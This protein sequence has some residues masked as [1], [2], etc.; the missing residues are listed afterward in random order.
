LVEKDSWVP[1]SV[2]TTPELLLLERG[3]LRVEIVPRPFSLTIRRAGRRLLRAGGVWVADGS[4]HDHFVQFTEGVVAGEELAPQERAL[5]AEVARRDQDA[6]EL[7]LL[8]QGG[9]QARLRISLAAEDRVSLQLDADGAPLRLALEW[10][11]RSE[12]RFVGLGARHRT[13]FDQEDGRCSS[14]PTGATRAATARPRCWRRAGSL[15][16]TALRCPGC[17]PAGA[18]A[19]GF[20]PTPT[21]HA[22]SS[23]A[24]ECRCQ[25]ARRPDR[26][27]WSSYAPRRRR[28]G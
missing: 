28:R 17:S 4:V 18:T 10:D 8:L 13:Q 15:R 21:A 3:V 25:R 14:A 20:G 9:R 11:R 2:S 26:Y 1:T 6:L 27:G 23:P 24:I 22:S 16:V 19:C 7:S 5:R 12:E